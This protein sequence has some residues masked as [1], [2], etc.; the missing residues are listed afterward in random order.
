MFFFLL[1]LTAF[2]SLNSQ[3]CPLSSGRLLGSDQVP[4]PSTTAH[5][6]SPGSKLPVRRHASF[7]PH[8]SGIAVLYCLMSWD[9]WNSKSLSKEVLSLLTPSNSVTIVFESFLCWC[10]YYPAL[11]LSCYITYWQQLIHIKISFFIPAFIWFLFWLWEHSFADLIAFLM[12]IIYDHTWIYHM[13]WICTVFE[14]EVLGSAPRV[15]AFEVKRSNVNEHIGLHGQ[16]TCLKSMALTVRSGDSS[17]GVTSN[18]L[19]WPLD[20]S[21]LIQNPERG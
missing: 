4:S 2:V 15:V 7:S 19:P 13:T 3:L 18:H 1:T 14:V 6:C 8:L 9:P 20:P 17:W 5:T 11:T 21:F 10:N 12:D 16:V